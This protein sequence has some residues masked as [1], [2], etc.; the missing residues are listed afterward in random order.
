MFDRG[1]FWSP[2][3]HW[4]QARIVADDVDIRL[5][6]APGWICLVSG[7]L[8]SFLVR[9]ALRRCLGPRDLCDAPRYALRLAPDRLLFVS[10]TPAPAAVSPGW[11]PDGIA[12]TEVTDGVVCLDLTGRGAGDVMRLAGPYDHDATARY[13]AESCQM[14]FAGLKVA[15]VRLEN[16]WRLHV[17]RPLATA[18]WHWLE[19]SLTAG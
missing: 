3:P 6:P 13:D 7:D 14:I 4:P 15:V 8:D 5:A 10:D 9:Q 1:L 19:K 16:G 12:V 2:V 18:L 11:S 17:E